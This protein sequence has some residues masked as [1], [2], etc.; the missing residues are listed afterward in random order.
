M[1][2]ALFW[3]VGG[4]AIAV[5]ILS[6]QPYAGKATRAIWLVALVLAALVAVLALLEAL[7]WWDWA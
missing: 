2:Q 1:T 6:A 7:N 3:L 5:V 4:L